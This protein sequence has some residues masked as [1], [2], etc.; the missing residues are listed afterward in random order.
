ADDG[1]M[2][3]MLR[4]V[5]QATIVLA[6]AVVDHRIAADR[7]PPWTSAGR[8]EQP[9]VMVGVAVVVGY[10][11]LVAIEGHGT[12]RLHQIPAILYRAASDVGDRFALGPE[13]LGQRRSRIGRVGLARDHANRPFLVL[14]ANA[15][16]GGVG[17]HPAP[18]D[19][20]LV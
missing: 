1:E 18:D 11:R 7:K 6:G 20:V 13:T 5:P 8:Q 15:F 19:Q 17:R 14:V 3:C 10:L 12:P 4:P 2:L 16:D 9:L